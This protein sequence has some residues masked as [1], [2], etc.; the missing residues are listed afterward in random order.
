MSRTFREIAIDGALVGA[1]G[2][3]SAGR[4]CSCWDDRGRHCRAS[5]GV[6]GHLEGWRVPGELWRCVS[7]PRRTIAGL[8]DACFGREERSKGRRVIRGSRSP[9]G[10]REVKVR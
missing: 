1:D 4:E 6:M 10:G 2:D 3:E 8:R 9:A 5:V 7:V